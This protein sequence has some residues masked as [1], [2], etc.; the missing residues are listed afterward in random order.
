MKNGLNESLLILTATFSCNIS[1]SAEEITIKQPTTDQ[2]QIEQIIIQSELKAYQETLA[3]YKNISTFSCLISDTPGFEDCFQQKRDQY[4][5]QY[6]IIRISDES[7][8]SMPSIHPFPF[9]L[10]IES[11]SIYVTP[12][13]TIINARGLETKKT[14]QELDGLNNANISGLSINESSISFNLDSTFSGWRKTSIKH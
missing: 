1:V 8:S 2:L 6:G 10:N 14:I 11:P 9:G 13:Y 3:T 12:Q 5:E 7:L 4:M